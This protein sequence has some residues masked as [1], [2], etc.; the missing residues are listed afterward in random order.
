MPVLAFLAW[1][2][3]SLVAL[4]FVANAT[5]ED[6]GPAIVTSSRIGLPQPWHPDADTTPDPGATPI[7]ASVT[8]SQAVISIQ[9]ESQADIQAITPAARAKELTQQR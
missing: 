4:L 7:P 3:L 1:V 2:G 9:A 6:H 8:T 5:L